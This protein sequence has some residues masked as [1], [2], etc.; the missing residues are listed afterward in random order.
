MAHVAVGV[1]GARARGVPVP[2][3]R[4]TLR[5]PCWGAA[6]ARERIG[7]E[8]PAHVDVDEQSRR[9]AG[10]VGGDRRRPR[11]AGAGVEQR[12]SGATARRPANPTSSDAAHAVGDLRNKV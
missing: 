5:G 7:K 3:R 8:H 11:A 2:R 12:D 10:G 1:R 4:R 6:A 9:D